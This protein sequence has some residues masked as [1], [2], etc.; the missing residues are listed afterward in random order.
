M[1]PTLKEARAELRPHGMVIEHADGYYYVKR[2]VGKDRDAYRTSDLRD[3][4]TKGIAIARLP[5]PPS[6]DAPDSQLLRSGVTRQEW[7]QSVREGAVSYIAARFLGVGVYDSR[8]AASL[9]EACEH[10]RVMGI[11]RTLIYA[12]NAR[13][14]SV[15]VIAG[16]KIVKDQKG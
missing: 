12:V 15:L 9:R 6:T 13:G 7:E 5:P 11:E 4:V 2:K 14:N 16:G 1:K 8:S 3:A 10:A